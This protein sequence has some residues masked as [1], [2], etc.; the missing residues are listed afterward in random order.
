LIRPQ[1]NA[2]A[3]LDFLMCDY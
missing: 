2:I 1:I 3:C